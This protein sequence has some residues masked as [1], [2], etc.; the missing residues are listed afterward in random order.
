MNRGLFNKA[1]VPGLFSFMEAGFKE[2]KL[3]Y[4]MVSKVKGSKRAYEESAYYAG[5][6]L[7]TEKPEGEG[8]CGYLCSRTLSEREPAVP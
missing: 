2:E 8:C 4:P 6:G 3:Y 5:L 1:V 7:M